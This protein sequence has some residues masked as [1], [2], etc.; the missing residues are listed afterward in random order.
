MKNICDKRAKERELVEGQII[1]T[2]IQHSGNKLDDAWDRPYKVIRKI[3]NNYEIVVP[4]HCVKPKI[5]HI[6][7]LKTIQEEAEF[8][9]LL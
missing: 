8:T 2:K 3:R 6:N 1:L 7:N 4:H 5:F 9:G